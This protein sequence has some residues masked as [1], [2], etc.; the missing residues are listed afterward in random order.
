MNSLI[1]KL[2]IRLGLRKKY[3]PAP[4]DCMS[5]LL[6]R[7]K[8]LAKENHCAINLLGYV[9]VITPSVFGI[10]VPVRIIP[11]DRLEIEIWFEKDNYLA[12]DKYIID[13]CDEL[14]KLKQND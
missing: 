1:H 10:G 3:E 4:I 8:D 2:L 12:L 13:C 5:L 14:N 9:W 7:F 6:P 11:L